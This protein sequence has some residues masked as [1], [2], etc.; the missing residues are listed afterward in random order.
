MEC[1]VSP[2]AASTWRLGRRIPGKAEKGRGFQGV[3]DGVVNPA[4]CPCNRNGKGRPRLGTVGS[5]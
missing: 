3:P 4:K 2:S 1:T 5:S